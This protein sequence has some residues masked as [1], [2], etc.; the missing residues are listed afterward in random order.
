LRIVRT[1]VSYVFLE[2]ELI[3]TYWVNLNYFI[4]HQTDKSSLY[5]QNYKL[6]DKWNL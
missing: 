6:K 4:Y 3:S 1:S 5:F 2:Y